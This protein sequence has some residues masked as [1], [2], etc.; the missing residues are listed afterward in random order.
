M[1]SSA[2]TAL[3]VRSASQSA[4]AQRMTASHPVVGQ[5]G[6]A[7]RGVAKS[8]RHTNRARDHSAWIVAVEADQHEIEIAIER[9]VGV[10]ERRHRVVPHELR[11]RRGEFGGEGL[12]AQLRPFP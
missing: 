11:H 2:L 8:E 3:G 9:A 5:L 4:C 6:P 10:I 1:I 7:E 12:A